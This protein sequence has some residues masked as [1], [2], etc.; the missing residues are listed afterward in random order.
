MRLLIAR[1]IILSAL[2]LVPCVSSSGA[3]ENTDSESASLRLLLSAPPTEPI[4]FFPHRTVIVKSG[5]DVPGVAAFDKAVMRMMRKWNVPGVGLAIAKDGKLILAR[6]YGFQDFETRTPMLPDTQVLIG[7]VS[8]VITSLAVLRLRDQGRLDL[9]TKFM[10]ILSEYRVPPG[11][12]VRLRDITIRHLLEHAGGW[13]RPLINDFTNQPLSIAKTLGVSTP[14]TC[15][16]V[17]RYTMTQRLDFSPGTRQVYSSAGFCILGRVIE[18]VA[19]QSYESYVREQ[20]LAPAG[21]HAMSIGRPHLSGRLPNEAKYYAFTSAPLVDSLFSGEGKVPLPYCCDPIAYEGAGAWV[22]SAVDLT[23]IM[24]ELDGSRVKNFLST[25]SKTQMLANNHL[26]HILHADEAAGSW[27]GLGIN[28]GPDPDRYG[29]AGIMA[30]SRTLL[31]HDERGYVMAIV[32]NT[33]PLD[34]T[35]F[36][37][38]M[39]NAVVGPLTRELTGSKDDLYPQFVSPSVPARDP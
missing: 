28:V 19:G 5:P 20:V 36:S 29:H 10:D 11:G 27:W 26:P 14:V 33:S 6:G 39:V 30:G 37:A 3:A 15:A 1:Y 18:K 22:G 31:V 2:T 4:R 13:D 34:T 7:S 16:D 25:D 38:A 17:V 12:D 9:D 32:A 8:K 23:R 35:G 24:T 21:V